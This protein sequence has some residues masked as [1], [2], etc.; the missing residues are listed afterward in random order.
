[1]SFPWSSPAAQSCFRP[2]CQGAEVCVPP[3]LLL[4][5]SLGPIPIASAS[6]FSKGQRAG[7]G[8]VGPDHAMNLHC[9]PVVVG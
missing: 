5:L 1:M 9:F 2:S 3:M 7:G 8:G 4:S 6:P